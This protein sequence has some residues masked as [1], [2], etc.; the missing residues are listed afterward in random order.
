MVLQRDDDI[1]VRGISAPGETVKI[2][3]GGADF[4]AKAGEDGGWACFMGKFPASGERREMRITSETDEIVIRDILT[5]DVWLCSG[6]SNMELALDRARHNYPDEMAASDAML[7]Q[8]RVPQ[9]YNF[10]APTSGLELPECAWE[11]FSPE[12]APNFTAVGYFFAKK[13]RERFKIPVGLLACAVGGTPVAAW[14]SRPTLEK[15]NLRDEVAE[16]DDLA[17]NPGRI[18]RTLRD[19]ELYESDYHKRLDE[20]D[21]G[22]K[23]GWHAENRDD[24]DWETVPLCESV[25]GAGAYW[26]RRTFDVPPELSGAQAVIFLGTAL[27]MDE[28]YLNGE[29]IGTAYYRY[30][31]REYKF[32]L[33][34]GKMTLAARLLCFN[35]PGGFTAGKNHFIA[36]ENGCVD[37]SGLWKRR[38]GTAFEEKK[39]QTFFAY[40]PTGLFNGMISPLLE[41]AVKGVIWY[42]G[43]SDAH[44]PERYGEKMRALI[45]DWREGWRDENMPFLLT[46]LAYYGGE[47]DNGW[48]ALRAQQ[49]QCLRLKNTGL[50]AAYDL[51]EYNDLHPQNKRD[52]GERLAR[53]AARLAYGE[54]APPNMFEMY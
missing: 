50:A 41:Y 31:P 48:E 14:M 17:K 12:T 25:G 16:A 4:L 37:L 28:V 42:Q 33:P 13:L 22:V 43:E 54:T 9:V 38:L 8:L 18:G 40:K 32:T 26:Y 2:N 11:A 29:K 23:C 53:L 5:G 6:Q 10:N 3:F 20:A 19:Y 24:G 15:L 45:S 34:E 36:T 52:V 21:E 39:P 27:D 47:G 46:Q 30:P 44:A 49:K 51:G 35:A 7:R 1:T